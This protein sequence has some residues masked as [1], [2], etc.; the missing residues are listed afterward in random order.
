M[1]PTDNTA[2]VATV[3]EVIDIAQ[4]MLK[5]LDEN[6]ETEAKKAT[7]QRI[8]EVV[9]LQSNTI[10]TLMEHNLTLV[11]AVDAFAAKIETLGEQK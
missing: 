7:A 6:A 10:K 4:L 9:E 1:Q 3:H 2:L 5:R 11:D 8:R